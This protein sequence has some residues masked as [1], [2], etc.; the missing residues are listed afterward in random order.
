[1]KTSILSLYHNK[2]KTFSFLLVFLILIFRQW[3]RLFYP[4]LWAED[5]AVFLRD[6]IMQDASSI[7]QQYAGYYH[8]LPRLV[9]YL[10]YK[11][12]PVVFYPYFFMLVSTGI[13]ALTASQVAGNE[14]ALI[15]KPPLI[16]L[17]AS[18]CLCIVP[19]LYEVLGNLANLHWVLFL[20]LC[21]YL[22]RPVE[23]KWQKIELLIVFFIAASTGEPVVLI[24]VLLLRLVLTLKL[25]NRQL[26]V[27]NTYI[28]LIVLL[29]STLNFFNR[30]ALPTEN[31]SSK[32]EI[33]IGTSFIW[34]QYL[35][36]QP[37]L[38]DKNVA[39]FFDRQRTIYRYSGILLG[40]LI[41]VISFRK[42]YY[43]ESFFLP[44]LLSVFLV[45]ILTWIVRPGSLLTYINVYGIWDGRYSFVLS[46][47]GFLLWIVLLSPLLEKVK[48][49]Y[50]A[51]IFILIYMIN[52]AY[53]FQL[54]AYDKSINWFTE[55]KV[56]ER[57]LNTGC[58]KAVNIPI[59]PVVH[60]NIL[61]GQSERFY[62][63]F[64]LQNDKV[65]E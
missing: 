35:M 53:R 13:Y 39:K 32:E 38:G 26:L 14:F 6:A 48:F 23:V 16:R 27:A 2:P 58:P 5:G 28:L 40:I 7:I 34:N 25:K 59:H 36:F 63:S 19:G 22:I 41:L 47:W 64:E 65:C 51:P 29:F 30:N 61:L 9:A 55:Y 8:T 1:M 45:P 3:E 4:G 18:V 20:L 52:S 15:I 17:L 54:K 12:L 24:P 49:K 33:V 62:F 44:I 10:T 43:L 37:V 11:L 31:P 42:K 46:P 57:A 60:T 50:V 56:A 21:F